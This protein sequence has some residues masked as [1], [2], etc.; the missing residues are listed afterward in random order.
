M[1]L[2]CQCNNEKNNINCMN[3]LVKIYIYLK[4][5]TYTYTYIVEDELEIISW[6]FSKFKLYKNTRRKCA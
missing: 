5:T 1:Q 4:L 6:Q 3:N 2:N